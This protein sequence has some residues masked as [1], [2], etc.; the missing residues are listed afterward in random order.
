MIFR[1]VDKCGTLAVNAPK[2]CAYCVLTLIEYAR[3]D[4]RLCEGSYAG[5]SK[6]QP[7]TSLCVSSCGMNVDQ[8][9]SGRRTVKPGVDR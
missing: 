9:S 6:R 2:L 8:G 7:E 3:L 4:S 5:S 1:G